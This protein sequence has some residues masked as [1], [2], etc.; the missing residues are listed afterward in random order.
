MT[1]VATSVGHATL[2]VPPRP[3]LPSATITYDTVFPCPSCGNV[4]LRTDNAH[5]EGSP[6]RC[7]RGGC[8]TRALLTPRDRRAVG[9]R[10]WRRYTCNG[11]RVS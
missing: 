6:M 7:P 10:E 4:L 11:R 2:S 8:S 5:F 3:T 9:N 1:L